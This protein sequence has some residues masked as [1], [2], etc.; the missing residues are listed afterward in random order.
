MNELELA[1]TRACRSAW[2]ILGLDCTPKTENSYNYSVKDGTVTMLLRPKYHIVVIYKTDDYEIIVLNAY[3]RSPYNRADFI[4]NQFCLGDW[5]DKL[6]HELK[7]VQMR[8]NFEKERSSRL[9]A[10]A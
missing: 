4:V 10:R 6:E 5:L 7:K 2:E 1:V 8:R 3:K 9:N